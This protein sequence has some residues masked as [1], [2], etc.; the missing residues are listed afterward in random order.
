VLL[1]RIYD[2]CHLRQVRCSELVSGL[3][4]VEVARGN[5]SDF[6][7]I[8]CCPRQVLVA[9]ALWPLHKLPS[10]GGLIEL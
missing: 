1:A 3:P 2:Y 7:K 8:V 6:S 4:C 9:S 10:G 5:A